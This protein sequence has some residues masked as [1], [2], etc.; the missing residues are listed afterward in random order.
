MAYTLLLL[1]ALLPVLALSTP[2]L[3]N[4]DID[5]EAYCAL[6]NVAGCQSCI[7]AEVRHH[8]CIE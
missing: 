5:K 1:I 2:I 3:P 4:T 8:Y 6:H 7:D